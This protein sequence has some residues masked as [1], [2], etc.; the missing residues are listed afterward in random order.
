MRMA[1]E[2]RRIAGQ[3]RY[4]D[5]LHATTQ[6]VLEC[7][8]A[9]EMVQALRGFAGALVAHF[10]I[11]EQVE[12]PALHGL[13]PALA[14]ALAELEREHVRFRGDLAALGELLQVGD[15]AEQRDPVVAGF[16]RVVVA[17]REHESREESLFGSPAA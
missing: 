7:G 14:P 2:A 8:G 12:F 15:P 11:E 10:S 1:R 6:R 16:G 17:L 4:L 5:A 9:D 13:D 3:H